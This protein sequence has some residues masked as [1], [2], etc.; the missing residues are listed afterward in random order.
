MRQQTRH[1][2]AETILDWAH[3]GLLDPATASRLA[4][5]FH[6][7]GAPGGRHP[8]VRWLALLALLLLL[9][10]GLGVIGLLLA[11]T[12]PGL[13]A[14]LLGG[15][16]LGCVVKGGQLA[17]AAAGRRP[18]SGAELLTVGLG[19]SHGALLLLYTAA[20]GDF[21]D[22]AATWLLLLVALLALAAA[23][24]YRLRWPLML[25]LLYLFHG[26]G[27][28]HAYVG[29]GGYV[30]DI[31]DERMMALLATV[32]AGFGLFHEQRLENG[33]LR[34]HFG[35]GHCYVIFGLLYLNLSTWFLSLYPG[36]LEWVLLFTAV[37]IGQLVAGAALKDARFTGFGIVFLAIDLY[38]RL[39][40]Q[41]WD[42]LAAGSFLLVAGLL[43]LALG[44]A[45][46]WRA[47]R[48]AGAGA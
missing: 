4:A 33:P 35:F 9:S 40:E 24:H 21:G 2:L 19:L 20:G 29:H 31:V 34:R 25:G 46:E 36:G 44:I 28:G 39:F 43:G 42:R 48:A 3:R 17:T 5:D 16:A 26:A 12:P 6:G 7:D 37:G 45:F 14:L 10:S 8:L 18:W 23:Y 38:T 11:Q 27:S 32:C 47:R 41:F 22:R 15:V 13:I 30:A 1:R